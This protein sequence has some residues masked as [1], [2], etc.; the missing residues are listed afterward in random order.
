MLR[1]QVEKMAAEL[2]EYKKR[3][4]LTGGNGNGISSISGGVPSYLSGKGLGGNMTN[5]PSNLNFEFEFPRFGS[6]PGSQTFK[7]FDGPLRK[8]A[9]DN[10]ERPSTLPAGKP[11]LQKRPSESSVASFTNNSTNLVPSQERPNAKDISG[12]SGLFSP[13]ILED[14]GSGANLDYMTHTSSGT[15]RSSSDSA[16]G[17]NDTGNSTSH[18]SPCASMIS[19]HGPSS[20]CGTSPEPLTQSPIALKPNET[21]LG[22]IGEEHEHVCTASTEGEVTFCE[23]LNMACGNPNNPVPRAMSKP[24]ALS[25]SIGTGFDGI[26]WLAEQNGGQFDPVLYGDYREPQDNIVA[27]STFGDTF[28]SEA[29]AMPDFGSPFNAAPSPAA[30]KDLVKEMD[31]KLD[32]E[33]EV[34]PGEDNSRMLSCNNI[35]FVTTPG[36]PPPLYALT[37]ARDRLQSCDKV[38]SGDFDL[39]GLCSQL[40]QKARCSEKGA[41]VDEK[42]FNDVIK[43]FVAKDCTTFG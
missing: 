6:L 31:D 32:G 36:H 39:D 27:N 1:A 8:P 43:A 35:W 23:K 41:V 10:R 7:S 26:D 11:A 12:L 9:S 28:F 42:D 24:S 5:N 19:Q 15:S 20:S 2:R 3:L 16:T 17:N 33:D 37:S 4:T 18:S 21:L 40:Q 38:K 14:V 30:K 29:F 13:S 22:T 34:V 25:D